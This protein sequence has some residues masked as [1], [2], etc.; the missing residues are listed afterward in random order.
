[1]NKF[2]ITSPRSVKVRRRLRIILPTLVSVIAY[3]TKHRVRAVVN[4]G[5]SI[6][7][8]SKSKSTHHFR[9]EIEVFGTSA[10][11]ISTLQVP[12]AQEPLTTVEGVGASH[13]GKAGQGMMEEFAD[14][15]PPARFNFTKR[16]A[17]QVEASS[18]YGTRQTQ[19]LIA[20]IG[21]KRC[22]GEPVSDHSVVK[23]PDKGTEHCC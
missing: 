3:H 1:M 17:S 18:E 8:M 19:D 10:N 16:E 6:V 14:P 4:Q 20:G 21:R 15:A 2:H 5:S 11:E 22:C 9:T 7:R 12:K 23:L 13:T